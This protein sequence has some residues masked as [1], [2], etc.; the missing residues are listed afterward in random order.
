MYLSDLI[1]YADH[2]QVPWTYFQGLSILPLIIHFICM[3]I[4]IGTLMIIVF[5]HLI[6][7]G[8]YANY[9]GKTI[10][11]HLPYIMAIGI[12][13]AVAPYL[14]IQVIYGHFIYV[15]SILM[16]WYWLSLVL[17]LIMSYYGLYGYYYKFEFLDNKRIYL[18]G[19]LLIVFL[20]VGFIFVNNM[21][22]MQTPQNWIA[23]F[24][25]SK[26]TLLNLLDPTIWPRFIHF[27]MASIAIAGLFISCIGSLQLNK[28]IP[29]D[30][31]LAPE[32]LVSFG[33][34]W[35]TITTIVQMGIGIWF[36]MALPEQ[37]I[38]LF[39]GKDT[40]ATMVFI[41]ALTCVLV[42][43]Y[44]GGQ[45]KVWQTVSVII[46]TMIMMALMRQWI[47]EDSLEQYF[48]PKDLS[49]IPQYSP[50]IM[51][52]VVLVAGIV[53]IG[54]MIRLAYPLSDQS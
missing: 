51:F 37:S 32:K 6:N 2:I 47:R 46:P 52:L 22:L 30:N 12:N 28:K 44:L 50:F 35:F 40:P 31:L 41:A 38:Q 25:N 20:W 33:M 54:Y 24:K 4:L 39:M 49:F 48:T 8:R 26:G 11:P 9:L 43:I 45:K 21:T 13:F 14:F 10:S 27:I 5:D 16:A 7:Q 34:K 53:M 36:L 17:L 3:N 23:Y 18:I 15:S 1:P 42:A 29:Q 19:S